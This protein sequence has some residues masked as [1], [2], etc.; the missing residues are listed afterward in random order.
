MESGT[1]ANKWISAPVQRYAFDCSEASA[2]LE[3]FAVYYSDGTNYV[4]PV[5]DK[6]W[7]PV[8][9][10][11]EHEAALHLVCTLKSAAR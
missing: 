1:H 9:P 3:A 6:S 4:E 11:T 7:R 5:P 2:M 10:E 8:I